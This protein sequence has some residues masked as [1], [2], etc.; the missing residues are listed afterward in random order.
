MP[1]NFPPYT[2]TTTIYLNSMA[3]Q[4]T[5]KA[6]RI[7][8]SHQQKKNHLGMAISITHRSSGLHDMRCASV[9]TM[10]VMHVGLV[11][12]YF[13]A[14][15]SWEIC[16]LHR[17]DRT[18]FTLVAR[19]YVHFTNYFLYVGYNY[20][21][22][23]LWV[24]KIYENTLTKIIDEAERSIVWMMSVRNCYTIEWTTS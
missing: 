20:H 13:T 3:S 7:F 19:M 1:P 11:H 8:Y 12:I 14:C 2:H 6:C 24:Y 17:S 9:W 16:I 18:Q 5:H 21:I 22:M 15:N 4:K 10:E 23:L